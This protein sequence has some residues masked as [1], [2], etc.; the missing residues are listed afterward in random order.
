ME[1]LDL[2]KKTWNKAEHS[3]NTFS[4]NDIY[5]M[6]HKKSSSIVKWIFYISLVELAL[7]VALAIINPRV[8]GSTITYPFILETISYIALL[9]IVPFS[10]LF[11]RNYRKISSTDNVKSLLDNIFNTRKTVRLYIIVN[12]IIVGIL[13]IFYSFIAYT[14]THGQLHGTQEYILVTLGIILATVLFIALAYGIYYV[15]YGILLKRLKDNYNELK[16]I[17][18]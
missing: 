7:G 3:F 9:V 11:Y 2:L 14:Q 10:I 4:Q 18:K 6:L 12:L 5:N 13:T 1:E 8:S 16:K 17:D 15:I